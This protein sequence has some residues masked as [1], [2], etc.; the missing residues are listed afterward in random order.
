MSDLLECPACNCRFVFDEE[1]ELGSQAE[2][3]DCGY[4]IDLMDPDR[5]DGEEDAFDDLLV[6][7]LVSDGDFDG[8]FGDDD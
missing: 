8:N 4:I 2:C 1:I 7:D 5:V 6:M 3:P